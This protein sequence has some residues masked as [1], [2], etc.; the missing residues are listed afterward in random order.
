MTK[1]SKIEKYLE[2]NDIYHSKFRELARKYTSE[3]CKA[4]GAEY[5][6]FYTD[7]NYTHL[8][9][10]DM[11]F[12]A[13]DFTPYFYT[14]GK[15]LEWYLRKEQENDEKSVSTGCKQTSKKEK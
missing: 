11:E 9:Y 10:N 3:V 4:I 8:R 6:G 7:I 5:I 12:Q 1:R 14:G 13:G 15:N 2:I